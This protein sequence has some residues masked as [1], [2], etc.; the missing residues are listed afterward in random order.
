MDGYEVAQEV[1]RNG[2][3]IDLEISKRGLGFTKLAIVE[4]VDR[5][6]TLEESGRFV[7][8]KKNLDEVLNEYSAVVVSSRGF[9][10]EAHEK[11]VL[12]R[13]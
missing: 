11:L 10:K 4:C 1:D 7:E 9:A 3:R 2:I 5:R 12:S 13:I 8:R 6:V